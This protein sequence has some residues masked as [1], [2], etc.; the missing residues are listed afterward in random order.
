M[1]FVQ[2]DL[3]QKHSLLITMLMNSKTFTFAWCFR[4]F[5]LEFNNHNFFLNGLSLR[6]LFVFIAHL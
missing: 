1:S 3:F 5:I 2:V 4:D 6:D